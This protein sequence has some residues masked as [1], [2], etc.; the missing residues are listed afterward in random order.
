MNHL[1]FHLIN[2]ERMV[3]GLEGGTYGKFDQVEEA[4]CGWIK[5]KRAQK[6]YFNGPF[7]LKKQIDWLVLWVYQNFKLTMILSRNFL[8]PS[9]D[10]DLTGFYFL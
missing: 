7:L 1:L 6:I 2:I 3:L 4:S 10:F 8:R 9:F 5:K